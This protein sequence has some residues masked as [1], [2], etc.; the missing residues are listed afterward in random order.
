MKIKL[1]KYRGVEIEFDDIYEV[2]QARGLN[3]E[4]PS[5]ASLKKKIDQVN[6]VEIEPVE[7]LYRDGNYTLEIKSAKVA[8]VTKGKR[9]VAETV[10]G[11][12]LRF[13][14]DDLERTYKVE[15]LDDDEY[16]RLIREADVLKTQINLMH[17]ERGKVEAKIR[18]KL[19]DY[20]AEDMLKQ[21]V[22]EYQ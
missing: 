15:L 5:V 16:N 10:S 7:F 3:L 18:S 11:A 12:K 8:V 17:E 9:M 6:T 14:N 22:E 2:F 21:L 20:S 1:K 13:D 19:L 4:A